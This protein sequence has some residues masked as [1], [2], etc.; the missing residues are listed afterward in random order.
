MTFVMYIKPLNK[1]TGKLSKEET[2]IALHG[3]YARLPFYIFKA[4][5]H[6]ELYD[7]ISYYGTAHR[8]EI[9]EAKK[10]MRDLGHS[11]K[12]ALFLHI[13]RVVRVR[14]KSDSKGELIYFPYAIHASNIFDVY[15]DIAYDMF[16][17]FERYVEEKKEE[18]PNLIIEDATI[19]ELQK[20]YEDEYNLV[21][22]TPK[23]ENYEFLDIDEQDIQIAR[24]SRDENGNLNITIDDLAKE[25]M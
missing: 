25:E 23:K 8:K 13:E 3:D 21:V 4:S 22:Y 7:A 17:T 2:Q 15:F 19:D 9:Q 6:K 11:D 12:Y 24:E 14:D 18:Y 16:K 10:T 1:E 5:D 20:L